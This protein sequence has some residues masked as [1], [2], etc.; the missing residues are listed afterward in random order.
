MRFP[1]TPLLLAILSTAAVPVP[2]QGQI[3]KL[4]KKTVNQTTGTNTA[5]QG[6]TVTFDDETL[7]LTPARI[8]KLVEGERAAKQLAESPNGPAAIRKKL[9]PLSTRLGKIVEEHGDDI[10]TWDEK[11]RDRERCRD[12]AFIP[13]KDRRSEEFTNRLQADPAFRMKASQ[14]AMELQAAMQKGD[15]TRVR[16]VQQEIDNL[17]RPTAAD[18]AVVDKQCGPLVTPAIVQEY[19]DLTRQTEDLRNQMQEAE[20]DVEQARARASGMT[21]QQLGKACERIKVFRE[22]LKAKQ[23]VGGYTDDEREAL[24]AAIKAL[25]EICP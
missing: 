10:N 11:R 4:I 3:T 21:P 20:A 8:A 13:I 19:L 7:E 18:S 14:L 16:E 1:L 9:E 24:R 17:Q 15:S 25:D 5:A 2:A 6:D 22:A 12:D 23:T